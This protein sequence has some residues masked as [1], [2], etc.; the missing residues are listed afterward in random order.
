M[1]ESGLSP[2]EISR[3][4]GI[5][6]FVVYRWIRRW[7]EE[8]TLNDR[9]RSGAPRRTT[10]DQDAQIRETV[11]ANPFTNAVKIQELQLPVTSRTVRKRV[12]ADGIH[13][14][15]PAVK[16]RLTERHRQGRL[17]F[18]QQHIDKDLDYW[19]RVI[20]TDEKLFVPPRTGSFIAGGEITQDMI[21]KISMK[22]REVDTW[23]ATC[24]GGSS[25]ME[26]ASLQK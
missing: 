5:S 7:E 8:G 9:S 11:E 24:G 2:S 10:A 3:E 14:R 22:L 21:D 13:H 18:A 17:Q 4:L 1:R 19:G 15:T 23:H 20:W 12:H 6:R 26:L 16:A 25:C